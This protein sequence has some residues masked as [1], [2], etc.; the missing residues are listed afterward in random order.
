MPSKA[1]I[2][3]AGHLAAMAEFLLR[4]YNVA[5]PEVDVGDDIFVVHDRTGKLWRIQ[6][7]T[8]IGKQKRYGWSGQFI[9]RE[10]QLETKKEPDLYY[11]LALR[12]GTKWEFLVAEREQLYQEREQHDVGT[13][14]AG[15]I[16]FTVRC[17]AIDVFCSA[18]NW[19]HF[20]NNWSEWPMLS[21]ESEQFS[22]ARLVS[23]WP[24]RRYRSPLARQSP[25]RLGP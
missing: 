17:H 5:Q 10:E 3:K 15:A 7:K 8:A 22:S 13:L 6:V 12:C 23:L 20:R 11:I 16:T 1:H 9:V 24:F 14:S 18:Q 25:P 19:R 2:G 21:I 4:G